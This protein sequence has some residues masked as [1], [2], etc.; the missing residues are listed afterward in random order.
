MMRMC[1]IVPLNTGGTVGGLS[2]EISFIFGP[3]L[4]TVTS[5]TGRSFD[6]RRSFGL[7]RSA[8]K[9]WSINRTCRRNSGLRPAPPALMRYL[10]MDD[11][12]GMSRGEHIRDLDRVLQ[13]AFQRAN[14]SA[15]TSDRRSPQPS[16]TA[17][18]A[19][20][21]SPRSLVTLGAFR[22]LCAWRGGQP[23][24]PIR[25][26]TVFAPMTRAIPAEGHLARG[27]PLLVRRLGRQ[28]ADRQSLRELFR[29]N[30]PPICHRVMVGAK[31]Y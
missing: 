26:P 18:I 8:S 24:L 12:L 23:K 7:N 2:A 22:R 21:R 29:K 27:N 19:R 30:Q 15:A 17:R 10:F 11:A 16:R 25:T 9:A 28:L 1:S 13:H 3:F 4:P 5:Y 31:H 6:S 20:S 14:V